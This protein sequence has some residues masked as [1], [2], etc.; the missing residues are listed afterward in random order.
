MYWIHSAIKYVQGIVTNVTNSVVPA[1]GLR[2]SKVI[3]K[4]VEPLF[5]RGHSLWM[6]GFYSSPHLS[7]LLKKND[8]N[9]AETLNEQEECSSVCKIGKIEIGQIYCHVKSRSDGDEMDGQKPMSFIATMVE[10][11][12]PK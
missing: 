12:R 10:R 9:V 4:F 11:K 5:G 3:V 6:D 2:T 8:V 1:D 7:F